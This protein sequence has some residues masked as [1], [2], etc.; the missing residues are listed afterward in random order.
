MFWAPSCWCWQVRG[1]A[2]R[3]STA[4][5]R[6]RPPWSCWPACPPPSARGWRRWWDPNTTA[7]SF[8]KGL[9]AS[10]A[11]R[12]KVHSWVYIQ[13]KSLWTLHLCVFR[14][15]WEPLVSPKSQCVVVFF[16]CSTESGTAVSPFCFF[17]MQS[18][19]SSVHSD[20][21]SVITWNCLTFAQVGT[22]MSVQHE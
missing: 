12:T 16:Y 1:W 11:W 4:R 13:G 20:R 14:N 21:F 8:P 22:V 9:F 18:L 15:K 5:T 19:L 6:R 10:S 17:K 2:T 3:F 7:C